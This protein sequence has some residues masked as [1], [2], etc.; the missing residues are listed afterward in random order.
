[1]YKS[2]NEIAQITMGQSPKSSAYNEDGNGLPFLQGRTTFGRMYP[3]FDTWTTEWNK[4]CNA[5]DILFTVR[6]PVG[7]VNIA[8]TKIALGRG[9]AG[10]RAKNVLP[11]Y[12]YYLLYAN[13]STFIASSS[14]TIYDS[15]NKDQLDNVKL[16]VHNDEEQR[17]I[18]D[19]IGSIDDLI[20]KYGEFLEKIEE[21][22]E[23]KY[24]TL[25]TNKELKKIQVKSLPL[26]ITDFVANGSFKDLKDNTEILDSESYAYFIRNT[27]L[28]EGV[29][30]KYVS[31]ETYKFLKKSS[32]NGHEIIISNVGDVG[33]V[34]LCPVLDKPMT[35][36]NNLILITNK[37]AE[38]NY[39]LYFL[40]KSKIG[41]YL[42]D[43]I[44][45]GSAQQKFNKTD[46]RNL[47]I[48]ILD[49]FTLKEFNS[50]C[51]VVYKDYD[52][53]QN[54]K[55]LLKKIKDNLLKKYFG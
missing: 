48:P 24:N 10:I 8:Q 32:L 40:F 38:E 25:I 28:K 1:M 20:E 12:L 26:T 19:T 30:N 21:L 46:L 49:D 35:L 52:K 34:F 39:Y 36:G 43:G 16:K 5:D 42:L 7:D 23:Q 27:D 14:G 31:E 29:F 9:V 54:K 13:K 2:L 6:A 18:V 33:S 15:I 3:S 17:H 41:Q 51:S 45:G 37:N 55:N 4:E 50:Y 47:E 44:T 11:K 53:I 22:L